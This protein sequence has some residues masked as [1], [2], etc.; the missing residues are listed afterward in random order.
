[1]NYRT[2]DP[3]ALAALKSALL[4]D[5]TDDELLGFLNSLEPDEAMLAPSEEEKINPAT[6]GRVAHSYIRLVNDLSVPGGHAGPADRGRGPGHPG[7]PVRRSL[8]RVKSR[9]IPGAPRPGRR[10]PGRL[11]AERTG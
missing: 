1:M 10:H 7:Q 8:D 5:G 6:W 9:R 2:A 4:A 3:A 11:A